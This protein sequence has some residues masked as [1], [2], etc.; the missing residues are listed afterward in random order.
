MNAMSTSNEEQLVG[1]EVVT[2]KEQPTLFVGTKQIMAY[3]TSALIQ[4][5]DNNR[6]FIK[7]RGNSIGR[8]VDVSQI[9]V[10][11]MSSAGFSI[12]DI[13]VGSEE[14]SSRDNKMRQ[15]SYISLEVT[16]ALK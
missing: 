11:K 7:A 13:T 9:I 4:L 12:T 14:L 15:V 6:L 16:K 10:R 8:A 5:S 3:V 1:E 2:K